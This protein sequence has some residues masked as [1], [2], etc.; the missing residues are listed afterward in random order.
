MR[1]LS[2]ISVACAWVAVV[3][4]LQAQTSSNADSTRALA[5]LATIQ[6]AAT[7]LPLDSDTVRKIV[8]GQR[9]DVEGAFDW[10]V[11]TGRSAEAA[12]LLAATNT[13]LPARA[14]RDWYARVLEMPGL[15]DTA[16]TRL[17]LLGT[18]SYLAFHVGDQQRTRKWA[19]ALL[20][21]ARRAGDRPRASTGYFRLSQVALRNHDLSE[22]HKINDAM[23][24]FCREPQP[25][26]IVAQ[27][28]E[29][30]VRNMRGEAA[31]VEKNYALARQLNEANLAYGQGH[32]RPV[33]VQTATIN[34]A[35]IDLARGVTS[36]VSERIRNAIATTRAAGDRESLAV[37]VA[38]LGMVAELQKD[39]QTAARYLG[40]ASMELER[41]G[42]LPDPAD[43]AQIADTRA[44]LRKKL[45]PAAFARAF[46]TGRKQKLDDVL[47]EIA[48]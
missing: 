11:A 42:R 43:Q 15:A 19:Q 30:N 27:R 25:D 37:L 9:G 20:D 23:L 44:R 1:K 35:L 17:S 39:P 10:F 48:H 29:L 28:C 6:Q 38:A 4:P 34:L 32:N 5:L 41:L 12:R 45:G 13:Y 31:R 26:T 36:G 2:L 18:G 22:F 24:V 16:Q 14:A 33:S 7:A 3:S 8:T 21:A 46:T 40:V 47:V